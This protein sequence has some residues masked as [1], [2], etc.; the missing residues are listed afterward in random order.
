MPRACGRS[1]ETVNNK[2]AYPF[3]LVSDHPR[4]PQSIFSRRL[5][6]EELQDVLPLSLLVRAMLIRKKYPAVRIADQ[7]LGVVYRTAK[8]TQSDFSV[9]AGLG[10]VG[11]RISVMVGT[12]KSHPNSSATSTSNANV[13]PI[14]R[15]HDMEGTE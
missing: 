2:G 15:L 4:D 14:P 5:L 10:Y 9:A 3:F 12:G 1:L 6:P 8:S 11:P 13:H 7:K